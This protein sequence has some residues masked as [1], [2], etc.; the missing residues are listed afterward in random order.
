MRPCRTP[1]TERE[2]VEFI[3]QNWMLILLALVSGGALLWPVI[4]SGGS[5]LEPTQAV[6][7]INR[8]K[9]VVIDVCQPDEYARGHVGGA[10]NV[11][12]DQ[13]EAQLPQVVKNKALPVLMVCQV[14][15][16]SARAAALAR[17]L[18]Y[19]QANSLNGGL[20]AWQGAG[21][22]VEKA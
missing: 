15:A 22:P 8:Q 6:L 18:G 10:R 9:A 12:L 2:L 3:T 14:G 20:K 16:R 4:K 11:P 21:L 19:E 1:T 7:L 5:G 13:L 17:K